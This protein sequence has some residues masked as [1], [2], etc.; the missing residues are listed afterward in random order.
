MLD[1]IDRVR[2]ALVAAGVNL[3]DLGAAP[4]PEWFA[5]LRHGQRLPL[6]PAEWQE[7]ADHLAGIAVDAVLSDE[8]CTTLLGH[9]EVLTTLRDLRAEG[10]D[11]RSCRGSLPPD[12]AALRSLADSIRGI[13]AEVDAS[14]DTTVEPG[15][16]A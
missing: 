7:T 15:R 11:L 13:A 2:G 6:G 10:M 1:R 4:E 12:A 16:V 5:E 14:A 8:A 3:D 9:I